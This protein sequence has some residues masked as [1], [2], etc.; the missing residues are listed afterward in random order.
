M[1]PLTPHRRADL[2]AGRHDPASAVLIATHAP[3]ADAVAAIG[4][5]DCEPAALRII[6]QALAGQGAAG[7]GTLDRRWN[8]QTV[9]AGT[10]LLVREAWS[11]GAWCETRA[12]FVERTM[13]LGGY[14]IGPSHIMPTSGT[15]R[16]SSPSMNDFK[17]HE[18]VLA[19]AATARAPRTAVTL[20][21]A[22]GLICA[23]GRR[24]GADKK[25][26]L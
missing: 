1:T 24:W 19:G 8:W 25:G 20:A 23:C 5:A 11:H 18:R 10:L 21:E 3:L 26:L 13:A 22:E 17:D 16:F 12:A 6:A 14:A 15:A 4:A 2:L 7:G 9:R